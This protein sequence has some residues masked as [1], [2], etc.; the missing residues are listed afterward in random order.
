MA[1][2]KFGFLSYALLALCQGAATSKQP[3]C[4]PHNRGADRLITST[5]DAITLASTNGSAVVVL[6]YGHVIEGIPSFDVVSIEGDT[7]LLEIT[8]AESLAALDNY[9][10]KPPCISHSNLY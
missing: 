4:S 6:D 3:P 1:L 2:R 9:M 5:N 10:V 8:Y 7:S